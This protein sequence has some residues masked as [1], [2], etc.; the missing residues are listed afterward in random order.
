L[1]EAVNVAKVSQW[2]AG[3]ST[4]Y[5]KAADRGS[6]SAYDEL[7]HKAVKYREAHPELSVAQSFAKVFSDPANAQLARAERIE[8]ASR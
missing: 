1:R 4:V 3:G 5:A 6:N 7:M 2:L 8:S